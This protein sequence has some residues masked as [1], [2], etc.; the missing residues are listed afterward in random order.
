MEGASR[1]GGA[2][3]G[4]PRRSTTA[5]G[6]GGPGWRR[7]AA[8]SARR[9]VRRCRG[10][11]RRSGPRCR[12]NRLPTGSQGPQQLRLRPGRGEPRRPAGRS[13][14]DRM[15]AGQKRRDRGP[16]GKGACRPRV[17]RLPPRGLGRPS[18]SETPTAA[19]ASVGARAATAA[20]VMGAAA[21]C[22]ATR[23]EAGAAAVVSK[24]ME[25]ATA[26]AAGAGA[27]LQRGPASAAGGAGGLGAFKGT[28]CSGE[29]SHDVAQECAC[30][31]MACYVFR[32]VLSLVPFLVHLLHA[33][34]RIFPNLPKWS[35]AISLLTLLRLVIF[36][37]ALCMHWTRRGRGA[38]SPSPAPR[39][40]S[41]SQQVHV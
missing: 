29:C 7:G 38:T 36:R 28:E 11:C 9:K 25:V 19:A 12:W 41:T 26:A 32:Y 24:A 5:R 31:I 14:G 39:Y 15:T 3:A 13:V 10:E 33:W 21:W 18:P 20:A 2:A 37:Y 22:A 40:L 34:I 8:P 27:P 30:N 16:P 1:R 4:D 6:P 35:V 17:W 23:V